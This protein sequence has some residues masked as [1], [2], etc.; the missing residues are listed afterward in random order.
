MIKLRYY[1]KMLQYHFFILNSLQVCHMYSSRDVQRDGLELIRQVT[2]TEL[3]SGRGAYMYKG[4]RTFDWKITTIF[5]F[6]AGAAW[7]LN[8]PQNPLASC[9][10][11]LCRNQIAALYCSF[12]T[13]LVLARQSNFST[14]ARPARGTP[15]CVRNFMILVL[16]VN[17]PK[18]Q[19]GSSPFLKVR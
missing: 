7:K 11:L 15:L 8:H 16:V 4:L 12:R 18:R 3:R 5:R 6:C 2:W 13:C 1:H 10:C 9:S 19:K 17:N 14:S